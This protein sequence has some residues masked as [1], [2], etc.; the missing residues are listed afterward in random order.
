MIPQNDSLE[1][2]AEQLEMASCLHIQINMGDLPP[3]WTGADG[4]WVHCNMKTM[5]GW[6]GDG[7]SFTQTACLFA[8]PSLKDRLPE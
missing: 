8:L 2:S 6:L 4:I 7:C 1:F 5:F 3:W